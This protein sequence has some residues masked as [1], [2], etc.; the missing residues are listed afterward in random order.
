MTG[1]R[2]IVLT[3]M[4]AAVCEYQGRPV[5]DDGIPAMRGTPSH[6]VG[7]GSHA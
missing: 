5:A 4:A 6:V 3:Q 2:R 1:V 7:P